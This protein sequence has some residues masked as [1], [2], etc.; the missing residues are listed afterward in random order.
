MRGDDQQQEGMWSYV[1]PEKRVPADHP[2]RPIREM[3]NTALAELSPAFKRLYSDQ[4]RPS[5]PPEKLLRAL[6]LQVFFSIRSERMLME[7]L[8]Y[9]LLFRWFVGLNMDDPIWSP[10]TFSKNRERLLEGKIADKFFAKV[11]EQARE[12]RLLSDEHFTVDGTLIEAW[13]GHKSF[14]PKDSQQGPTDDPGNPTIDFRGQKRCNDTHESTT[15]PEAR[16]YRKSFGTESKLCYAGHVMM[17]N[18]HGLAVAAELTE[19]NGRS[20]R[21]AGLRMTKRVA[22]QNHVTVGADKGYDTR[23]FVEEMRELGATPH[24]AAK[25][26]GSAV[27]GRT[28]RHTGYAISQRKRKLVEEIFGWTKTVGGL[29]KTRHRGRRRVGWIFTFALAAYNLIR[30]RNLTWEPA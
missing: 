30:I 23:Q 26:R 14:R 11:L 12:A 24:V 25:V 21:E 7:Q 29:R 10:T 13:A 5:I 2:L 8:D 1:A 27:D 22:R 4:G 6:L 16:L 9:N 17:D 19:A 18:R 28:T 20:E 15:D 3:V